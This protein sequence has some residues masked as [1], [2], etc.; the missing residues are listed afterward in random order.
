VLQNTDSLSLF[1]SKQQQQQKNNNNRW[2]HRHL[3]YCI[4]SLIFLPCARVSLIQRNNTWQPL[5]RVV[6]LNMVKACH[7][8]DLSYMSSKR[9]MEIKKQCDGLMVYTISQSFLFHKRIVPLVYDFATSKRMLTLV[10]VKR[11][12]KK[13][14]FSAGSFRYQAH[15]SPGVCCETPTCCP[16]RSKTQSMLFPSPIYI[17]LSPCGKI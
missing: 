13:N 4:L 17:K 7:L 2:T 12:K 3:L 8:I 9:D 14:F 15:T 1:H 10:S 16:A 6:N 5:K 11:T